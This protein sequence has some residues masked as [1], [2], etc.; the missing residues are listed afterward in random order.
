MLG[1]DMA[2]SE[3]ML[4]VVG[5]VSHHVD[6]DVVGMQ[7]YEMAQKAASLE[8]LDPEAAVSLAHRAALPGSDSCGR[9]SIGHPRRLQRVEVRIGRSA[10]WEPRDSGSWVP[11]GE[12]WRG[13]AAGD[14]HAP[15]EGLSER[16]SNH[17]VSGI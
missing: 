16:S 12:D 3:L 14:V 17:C 10:R 1:P 2:A 15:G 5:N 9:G 8:A 4:G 11:S 13:F 6:G 7:M